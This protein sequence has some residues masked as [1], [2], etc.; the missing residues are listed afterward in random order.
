MPKIKRS[1]VNNSKDLTLSS[2]SYTIIPHYVI[3]NNLA[4]YDCLDL[5]KPR[6]VNLQQN[7][8]LCYQI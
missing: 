8:I 7:K 6:Q 1:F 5:Y 3:N 4:S 2:I